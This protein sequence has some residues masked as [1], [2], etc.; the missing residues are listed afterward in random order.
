MIV[1]SWSICC[2]WRPPWTPF[3][4]P[5]SSKDKNAPYAATISWELRAPTGLPT[6]S[7][8]QRPLSLMVYRYT[9]PGSNESR[10]IRLELAM[11]NT[12]IK[13][14]SYRV[15]LDAIHNA[16]QKYARLI[17]LP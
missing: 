8:T 5:P 3:A 17:T 11:E 15:T 9:S 7:C 13:S 2:T 1:R 6:V 12:T 4:S 10:E 16:F 14:S